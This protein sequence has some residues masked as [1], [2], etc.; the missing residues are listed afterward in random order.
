MH[1]HALQKHAIIYYSIREP[2]AQWSSEHILW[3]R[4]SVGVTPPRELKRI[5]GLRKGRIRRAPER[6]STQVLSGTARC[7]LWGPP[8]PRRVSPYSSSCLVNESLRSSSK[9][10]A[11]EKLL[12]RPE[13][14]C[15][16]QVQGG[17]RALVGFGGL[18]GRRAGPTGPT[19]L[20][21]PVTL[22]WFHTSYVTNNSTP[23][24]QAAA[25]AEGVCV[26][27]LAAL[28]GRGLTC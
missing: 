18:A 1:A 10:S 11:V 9:L 6:S 27:S 5:D 15:C 3:A 2:P 26:S 21:L 14:S 8:L 25:V 24:K 4:G 16:R 13:N 17:C 23:I 12:A 28:N 20:N 19:G 7:S 22:A